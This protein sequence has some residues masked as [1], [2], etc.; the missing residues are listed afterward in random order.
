MNPLKS[1]KALIAL[2]FA[3]SILISNTLPVYALEIKSKNELT[4]KKAD[5]TKIKTTELHSQDKS[6]EKEKVQK[7]KS[8]SQLPYNFLYFL[9]SLFMKMNPLSRP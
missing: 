8:T 3:G 6:K 1:K 4:L 2:L 9:I 5:S 7:S